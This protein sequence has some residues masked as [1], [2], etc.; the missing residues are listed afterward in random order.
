MSQ[1]LV[2]KNKCSMILRIH[3]LSRE[4]KCQIDII[5]DYIKSENRGKQGLAIHPHPQ[6]CTQ[7][8]SKNNTQL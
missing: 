5:T 4:L 2:D 7:I 1:M 8:P 3:L 6:K